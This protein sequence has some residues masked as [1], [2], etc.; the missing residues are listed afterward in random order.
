MVASDTPW[1]LV[2][3][4]EYVAPG[5]TRISSAWHGGYRLN[6]VANAKVELSLKRSTS[7]FF[8]FEQLGDSVSGSAVIM[9]PFTNAYQRWF[10]E[11][12]GRLYN[13]H[14]LFLLFF[15]QNMKAAIKNLT[16]SFAL[17]GLIQTNPSFA[18]GLYGGKIPCTTD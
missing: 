16:L 8:F 2:Q 5:I 4:A 3:T 1:G 6:S 13:V 18:D 15:S 17:L 7:G 14:N 9:T 11:L 10:T 12:A